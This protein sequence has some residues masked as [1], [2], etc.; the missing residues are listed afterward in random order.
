[1]RAPCCHPCWS[2]TR[3]HAHDVQTNRI[4]RLEQVK[5]LPGGYRSSVNDQNVYEKYLTQT[6]LQRIGS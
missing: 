2:S 5:E 6:A 3:V 4:T 1:M